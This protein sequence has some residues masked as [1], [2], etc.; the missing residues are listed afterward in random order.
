MIRTERL[1][2]DV[3]KDSDEDDVIAILSNPSVKEN[4]ICYDLDY[5]GYK[6]QFKQL[7]LNSKIKIHYARGI[8]LDN[9]LIGFIN[10]ARIRDDKIEIEMA[11]APDYRGQGYGT[12]ALTACIDELFTKGYTTV[13]TYCF[14]SNSTYANLLVKCGMTKL[15][16]EESLTYRGNDVVCTFY[17]IKK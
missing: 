17:T 7:K 14:K 16:R 11:L 6:K 5:D 13:S 8:F 2:L 4:Y 3:L 1:V 10:D 9:K 15:D 12:E